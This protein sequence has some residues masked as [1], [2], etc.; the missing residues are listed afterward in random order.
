MIADPSVG[1]YFWD[2]FEFWAPIAAG[3]GAVGEMGYDHYGDTGTTL[4]QLEANS[5][6]VIE[7]GGNDLDND[8]II[9]TTM[10]P[11]FMVSSAAPQPLW[12]EAMVKRASVSNNGV[13][14]F[15]GLAWDEGSDISL[16]VVETLVDNTGALGAFSFLGFHVDAGN[17]DAIDFVYKAEGGAD[18]VLIAGACVPVLA[19]YNKLGFKFQP[20][21][22]KSKQ[23]AIF[24]DGVEHGTHATEAN[25]VAATFP[26]AE[27]LAPTW[28]TKVGASAEQKCQL[29][30]WRCAQ[31]GRLATT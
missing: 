4:T 31:L 15:I 10:N 5:N 19:V 13:S 12:F 7:T 9:L 20:H 29:D 23:L 22:A 25:I 6:G 21:A 30:W 17:G 18:T 26:D 27:R 1:H 8:E 24:V 16:A 11:F 2:D 14:M 28:A 3:V